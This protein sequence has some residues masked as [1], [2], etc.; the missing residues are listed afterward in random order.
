[1]AIIAVATNS[2]GCR[3][4]AIK[5]VIVNLLPTSVMQD[6]ITI[7][8]GNPVTLPITY[9]P[10]VNAYLWGPSAGLSCITCPKPDAVPKFTTTYSVLY[11]DSV[12]CKNKDTIQ[13]NVLCKDANLFMPNTFSPNDDGRNDVFYP[14]G[15][16]IYSV[17][18]LRVFNRWGELVFEKA[19]F[20]ANNA[21]F[22]W[23]GIFKGAK[24]IQDVYIFQVEVYCENGQLIKQEGDIALIL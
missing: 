7:L 4:T 22:G 24:P 10:K 2:S 15:T 12:G 8:A 23:N 3:D 11:T 13:V 14:R 21:S 6:S 5:K 20:P 16:G 19:N 9:S 1:M 18:I 17:R